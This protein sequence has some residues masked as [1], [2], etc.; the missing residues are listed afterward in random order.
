[1]EN[2]VNAALCQKSDDTLSII[3]FVQT[4]QDRKLLLSAFSDNGLPIQKFPQKNWPTDE[5][6]RQMT[7]SDKYAYLTQHPEDNSAALDLLNEKGLLSDV[8]YQ[9]VKTR[10]KNTEQHLALES[11][12]TLSVLANHGG[13][14][15]R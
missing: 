1:M 10:L 6:S 13:Q 5:L 9:E 8:T 7:Q 2:I 14:L 4:A 12:T 15:S 3:M 11:V